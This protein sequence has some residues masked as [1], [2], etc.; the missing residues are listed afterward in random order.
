MT[1]LIDV[2]VHALDQMI[3]GEQE[4]ILQRLGAEGN[5]HSDVL[6]ATASSTNIPLAD[7]SV[8][9]ILTSPPYLTR[10]D[11]AVAHARELAVL[12]IDIANDRTLRRELMGTT[13]TR[14][15]S[16]R[17]IGSYG[18]EATSLIEQVRSHQS[19]ASAGY[20]LKQLLQYLDDLTSSLDEIS[21]V[22]TPTASM[23]LVVQDSYYKDI[24]VKLAEICA[25]EASTRGWTVKDRAPFEVTRLLTMMNTAAQAYKK[26]KVSETVVTLERRHDGSGAK[27]CE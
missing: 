11:Y 24:H 22:A 14:P 9:I 19:K 13:L 1:Q 12:S 15:L 27:V 10:L 18:V 23:A 4:T 16:G 26:G 21:R 25:E 2:P 3:V 17:P 7:S 20:Y 8:D 6:L 5:R